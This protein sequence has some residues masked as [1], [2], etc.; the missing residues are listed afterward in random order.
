VARF[1]CSNDPCTRHPAQF[2]GER[3]HRYCFQCRARDNIGNEEQYP[4]GD[5]D[6][7]TIVPGLQSVV[8][9]KPTIMTGGV[10]SEVHQSILTA[11]VIPSTLTGTVTFS[12]EGS[13]GVNIPAGLS[14]LGGPGRSQSVSVSITNGQ[15]Q[16]VLT[17][18][19]LE[20]SVTVEA[21][22][23]QDERFVTVGQAAG[24]WIPPNGFVCVPSELPA[25]GVS[26][27][28][29]RF[30]LVQAGTSTAVPGHAITFVIDSILDAN[31]NQWVQPD[32][33]GNW[34]PEYGTIIQPQGQTNA[35]GLATGVFHVGTEPAT[36]NIRAEDN[37]D[38]V[39]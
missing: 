4:G 8:S 19:D 7:C 24:G 20:E 23:E 36:I 10:A 31:T 17:S 13:T 30:Y 2:T 3:G 1:P 32:P 12:I 5:G 35:D 9:S 22:F 15:A 11:T 25:D 16:A 27:T 14:L 39:P 26:T 29:I 33:Y 34:P 28:E 18:S 21:T 6:T 37:N 38:Q